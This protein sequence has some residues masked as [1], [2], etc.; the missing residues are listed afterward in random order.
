MTSS[1]DPD[2]I[3]RDVERTQAELRSDIDALAAKVTPGRI[4]ERRVDRARATAGRW[5]ESVM[6]NHP[7][8]TVRTG[9]HHD[10]DG[11]MREA[12]ASANEAAQRATD[13]AGRAPAAA[14][15]Q[16][17]G[18][19]LAAGLIAFG[20]GWLVSSMLPSSSR[21]QDLAEQAEHVARERAEPVA[22]AAGDA[23]REVGDNLRGPAQDAADAVRSTAADAGST[24]AH[25]GRTAA[26]DVRHRT[27]DAAGAVRDSR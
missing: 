6:G 15:R 20:A 2:L 19:P 3:R 10:G 17:Q 8:T 7:G 11:R 5:K 21:E 22:R 25:E 24:V 16:T 18:N 9:T 12:A 14:R 26:D 23:A 4:V 13:T 1:D 27:Q